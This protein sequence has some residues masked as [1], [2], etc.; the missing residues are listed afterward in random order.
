MD[1]LVAMLI[2]CFTPATGPHHTIVLREAWRLERVV[3]L[4]DCLTMNRMAAGGGRAG[5]TIVRCGE[6]K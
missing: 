5:A 6:I 1:K 3:P 4:K 2:I